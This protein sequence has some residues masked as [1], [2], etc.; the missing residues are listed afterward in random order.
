MHKIPDELYIPISQFPDDD[1]MNG[2]R[3][4]A[5]DAPAPEKEK[6]ELEPEV[7]FVRASKFLPE[8]VSDWIRNT[9]AEH[10][11]NL[12]GGSELDLTGRLI[13]DWMDSNNA[14]IT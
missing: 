4:E 1:P 3:L 2:Y 13:Q 5:Y 7:R 6:G 9:L 12:L 11:Y 14:D 10:H 8:Y